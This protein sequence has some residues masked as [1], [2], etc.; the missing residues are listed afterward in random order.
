MSKPSRRR[1]FLPVRPTAFAALWVAMAAAAQPAEEA[2][3]A[4]ADEPKTL[5][6]VVVRARLSDEAPREV[7]FSV[8]VIGGQEM[9]ERRL[10]SVEEALWQIPGVEMNS[11]GGDSWNA[12]VRIRGVGALQKV[13][14]EDASVGLTVDGQPMLVNNMSSLAFDLERVEVLKGPQGT[15]LGNNSEAGA[16]NVI[17]ARPTRHFEGY[18]RS[19]IG[20]DRQRMAEGAISG[21]LGETVSARLAL[22]GTASDHWVHDWQTG[23][24]VSTPRDTGVRGTLLWQPLATTKLTL[25]AQHDS[26]RGHPNI[27]ALH[28]YG[29]PV[30]VDR[31]G[32]PWINDSRGVDRVGAT[33]EHDLGFA[34]LT[35][36]TGYVKAD[37]WM[38]NIPYEG[39]QYR[40][41]I[42]MAP[43]D[44]GYFVM[45]TGEETTSQELRLS[46]KPGDRVFWVA[47]LN[48]LRHQ[49]DVDMPF[50]AFDHFYP[51][52]YTNG[53]MLRRLESTSR[54]VFGEAT[55]PVAERLKLTTGLRHTWDRKR[56][57]ASW[58]AVPGNDGP[59]RYAE[60][61]DSLRDH[62]TTGRLGLGW[63]LDAQTN[64]Y[65]MAS[66]G[67]KS[68]GYNDYGTNVT[69]GGVDA[70][71]AAARVNAVEIGA[72]HESADGRFGLNAAL[73]ESRGK[74][75]HLLFFD[76]M[77]FGMYAENVD[78]RSR[79]LELS[80]F[81]KPAAGL[82]LDAALAYT[83]AKITGVAAT[84]TSG[85]AAG[86][87][88]P[89]SPKWSGSIGVQHRMPLPSFMGWQSPAWSTRLGL[90][91]ASSRAGDPQNQFTLPGYHQLDLR[92]GV[93]G[94]KTE[95]YLWVK[96]LTDKRYDS[97]G[98]YY[99]AMYEG[100]P[101]AVMGLPVR[102]R[103]V[104]VGFAYYF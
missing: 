84:S 72:K 3:T 57:R 82:T 98:Y 97:F 29:D 81:W 95:L 61:N 80:G 17:T 26:L 79:G 31:L 19:E 93:S 28:P 41:L 100:G 101:D 47:G 48:W 38:M 40:R 1:L 56:Q 13:S 23:A 90:R 24:V 77:T 46:S 45:R 73:F 30:T 10:F 66:R 92:T 55:F 44:G 11:N 102:G 5:E 35:S 94:G 18:V 33:L 15:L 67:Y 21:P 91:F 89:D 8:N 52:N 74:G 87:R 14:G 16:I 68:G 88:V 36:V 7:P 34:L 85:A 37:T 103:T 83:D 104:G 53:T 4:G 69:Q 51:T 49:R 2:R 71:Y 59:I 12:N 9:E 64:L 86:N 75:D 42:G 39:H 54:A 63:A 65:A 62:Y 6:P 70:P 32:T 99:P 58:Q 27:F 50:G 76:V 25:T 20:T 96:N 78:T 22:R 60:D 43:E